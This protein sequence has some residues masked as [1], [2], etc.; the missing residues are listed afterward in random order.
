MNRPPM[1]MVPTVWAEA[2]LTVG[3]TVAGREFKAGEIVKVPY[4]VAVQGMATGT[5]TAIKNADAV[6]AEANEHFATY[7]PDSWF[8]ASS[9]TLFKF[10]SH[11]QAERDKR[12]PIP[13]ETAH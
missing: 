12:N 1:L 5:F 9:Q 10:W 3:I 8:P 6:H 2:L 13:A 4:G 7:G 11:I